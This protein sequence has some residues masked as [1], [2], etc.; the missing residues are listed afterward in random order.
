M[1]GGSIPGGELLNERGRELFA[2]HTRGQD[3]I[4]WG[5][6]TARDDV[7]GR[8][9]WGL[10]T[11]VVGDVWDFGEHTIIFPIPRVKL[12]AGSNLFQNPGY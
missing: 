8:L 3:L 12:E 7:T 4:R 10:P 6:W 5:L 2:E 11:R 9:K 1:A